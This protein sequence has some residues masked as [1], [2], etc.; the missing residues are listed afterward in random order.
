MEI[1]L[2]RLAREAAKQPIIRAKRLL[3]KVKNWG[4]GLNPPSSPGSTALVRAF[5]SLCRA[6][7]AVSL[8]Q[9]WEIGVNINN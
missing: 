3:A 7:S 8:S 5:S 1:W 2:V 4:G 6:L 9:V